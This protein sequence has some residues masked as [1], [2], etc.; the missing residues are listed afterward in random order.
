MKKR[1][2]IS[3]ILVEGVLIVVIAFLLNAL[4]L[5]N[6]DFQYKFEISLTE[7]IGLLLT[8]ILAL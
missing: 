3:T 1:N 4:I 7:I 6:F 8:I 2:N 5:N